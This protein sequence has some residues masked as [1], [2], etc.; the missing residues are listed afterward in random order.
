[1]SYLV[2]SRQF[3]GLP[4]AVRERLYRRLK[5]LLPEDERPAIVEILRD[6]KGDLPPGW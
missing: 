3:E 4:A 2:Y 5:E 6:T 1:L